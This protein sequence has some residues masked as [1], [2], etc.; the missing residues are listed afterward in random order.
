MILLHGLFGAL[1]NWEDVISH[2]KSDYN[3][4][5][6][7]LPIYDNYKGD[8]IEYMVKFLDDYI[9]RNKLENVALVGNSLG[10]HVAIVYSYRYPQKVAFLVLTGSSGLYEN[11]GV[12]G[13]VKR[14]NMAYIRERVAYTFYDAAVA[15]NT[16]V[17]EVYQVTTNNEKCFAILKMAKSAQRNYVADILPRITTRTLLIWGKDDKIT[18]LD[19]ALQFKRFLPQVDLQ[20]LENCGHAPMMERPGEFNCLLQS[21]LQDYAISTANCR[22]V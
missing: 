21:F 19:V 15:T 3:I 5:V 7:L 22:E 1:S 8:G 10:G 12:G 14:G 2:F 16:L 13:F 18:P 4:H 11:T 20:V 17:T 6:P 9:E